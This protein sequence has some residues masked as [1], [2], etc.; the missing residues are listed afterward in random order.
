MSRAIAR[1]EGG[2]REL[3][4]ARV[5]GE[6]LS[7]AVSVGISQIISMGAAFGVTVLLAR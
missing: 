1:G 5:F 3:M 2:P 7:G 4:S 6:D